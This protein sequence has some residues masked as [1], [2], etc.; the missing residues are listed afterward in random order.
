M[1][2]LTEITELPT[3]WPRP[4]DDAPDQ[5][6]A[7]KADDSWIGRPEHVQGRGEGAEGDRH[8]R[9]GMR[10]EHVSAVQG[11]AQEGLP[12]GHRKSTAPSARSS[13]WERVEV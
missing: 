7:V 5:K 12:V 10:V 13:K 1:Y 6:V 9:R 2:L 4:K 8:D 3:M 11:E